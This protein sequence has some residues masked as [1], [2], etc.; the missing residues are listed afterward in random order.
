MHSTYS[1][2]RATN[3]AR[4]KLISLPTISQERMKKLMISQAK[5]DSEIRSIEAILGTGAMVEPGPLHLIR[6]PGSLRVEADGPKLVLPPEESFSAD[7]A[8]LCLR[9]GDSICHDVGFRERRAL[10]A[11]F[12][13]LIHQDDAMRVLGS[14]MRA[15]CSRSRFNSE[16]LLKARKGYQRVRNTATPVYDRSGRFVG[17]EGSIKLL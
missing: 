17:M 16:Y 3:P 13:N 5:M 14:W 12:A 10:D 1:S 11:G 15:V 2:S 7:I 4:P 6:T 9:V 8:G